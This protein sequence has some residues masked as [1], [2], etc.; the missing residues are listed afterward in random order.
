MFTTLYNTYIYDY[1]IRTG[2]L[3][4]RLGFGEK[5]VLNIVSEKNK[6]KAN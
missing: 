5:L 6:Q 1:F 3:F 2:P 4:Y